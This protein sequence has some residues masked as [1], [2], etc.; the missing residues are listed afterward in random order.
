MK[1]FKDYFML[2]EN[3]DQTNKHLTHLDEL[4][5]KK[6]KE[7]AIKTLQYIESLMNILK[8]GSDRKINMTVK[9]DGAPAIVCGRDSKGKF[10]LSTKS[11]FNAEPLLSYSIKDIKTNHSDA[12][13]LVIKLINAF[14]SLKNV[15][16]D[17]VYQG[18]MLFW[19]G[20]LQK[21]TID[22]KKYIGFRPNTILYT[23]PESSKEAKTLLKY[24]IGVAFHTKY[25]PSIDKD[26]KQRFINKQF[27][28]SVEHL[29]SKSA[30]IIDALFENKAGSISLT[31]LE[32]NFVYKTLK[33]ANTHINL[34]NFAL[35]DKKTSEL[36]NIFL[37]SKI[38]QGEFLND[39]RY[40]FNEFV[41][42]VGS[43]MDSEIEKLKRKETKIAEKEKFI[44]KLNT[45]EDIFIH[46]LNFIR[47]VKQIKDIFIQK[48]NEIMRSAAMGTF[49]VMPNG[50]IKVTNPEGYVAFDQDQNGIKFIDRL[51][52]SR[53]NFIL[54]KNWANDQ[55]NLIQ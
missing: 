40:S 10:F 5:L 26:G 37:N 16:F 14:N 1:K 50:D 6:G 17:G 36:I 3:A 51:E 29:K 35:L 13:G 2:M 18:D 7:G 32:T 49:L 22:N 48:Y 8:S 43:R 12:P 54:P 21:Y 9:I 30:Y 23:F 28:I 4:I 41:M 31:E 46:L 53:A 45:N 15:D 34:I 52:F 24:N 39:L 47:D 38:K 20:L 42:W 25:D 11:A 55:T 44:T 19:P 27:G 33:N